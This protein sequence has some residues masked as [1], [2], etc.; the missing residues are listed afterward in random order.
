MNQDQKGQILTLRESGETFAHIA[1]CLGLS[2]NTVKSFYRR[3]AIISETQANI[4]VTDNAMACPQCG[5]KISLVSGRKPKK[6]C[7]DECRVRWWNSHSDQVSRKALYSFKCAS[8]GRDFTAYGNAKRRY[9]SHAC[10]CAD[11]F[12]SRSNYH[13]LPGSLQTRPWKEAERCE[14]KNSDDHTCD[15]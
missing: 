9:C 15:N 14:R 7:S 12:G 6:F 8:C 1:A 3:N 11:R 10:Y 4:A 13:P 5:N 2:V